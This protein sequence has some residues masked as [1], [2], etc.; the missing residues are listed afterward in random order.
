MTRIHKET[1]WCPSG[2]EIHT[3]KVWKKPSSRDGLALMRDAACEREGNPTYVPSD[4]T[5]LHLNCLTFPSEQITAQG[6]S[7]CF[8]RLW[9]YDDQHPC[10][11]IRGSIH[12]VLFLTSVR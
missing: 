5:R 11:N 9:N 3:A 1:Y 4:T 10:R 7:D 6:L 2:A 12:L 8:H